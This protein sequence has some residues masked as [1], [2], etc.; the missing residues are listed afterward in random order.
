MAN[1]LFSWR[2]WLP[3][4]VRPRHPEENGIRLSRDRVYI[5]PTRAGLVY[6]FVV[7]AMLT[8]A[9]NY[10][11]ALGHALVFLLVSL[12]LVGMLH[13]YR[14]L[15]GLEIRVSPA[16]PVSAGEPAHFHIMVRNPGKY[17]R[18]ALEWRS[19]EHE[20]PVI[21]Q[22][23][24]ADSDGSVQ[25]SLP[26]VSRGV[27]SIPPLKVGSRYPL[28]L[29]YAWSRIWPKVHCLVY[30]RPVYTPL[31]LGQ[32]MAKTGELQ[33]NSGQ[34]DFS[35]FRERQPSDSLRHVAWKAAARDMGH[36][37]LLIKLFGGSSREELLLDWMAT[38]GD[39]E[40]RIS[41]LAGWVMDAEA[42]GLNYGLSIP[43]VQIPISHGLPHRHRC[44]EAL[45]LY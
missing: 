45:A 7:M 36:K 19:T 33:G 12:G 35:G 31:P 15:M 17:S 39:T 43:G 13:T 11:L 42:E 23:I 16:E 6:A 24:S 34:E 3:P 26:T 14:N 41:T 25:F 40:H 27:L 32:G 18:V 20:L 4:F 2:K 38:E 29:F 30:P 22:S 37:P 8:G 21:F 1:V 28:G 10:S 9:I 5:V 44:L